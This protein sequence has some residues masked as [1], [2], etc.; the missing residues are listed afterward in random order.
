MSLP[1]N[2]ISCRLIVSLVYILD[3][4][5]FIFIFLLSHIDYTLLTRMDWYGWHLFFFSSAD[6]ILSS[7]FFPGGYTF[8]MHISNTSS[9]EH[10]IPVSR[11]KAKRKRSEG[12]ESFRPIGFRTCYIHGA[13]AS[14]CVKAQPLRRGLHDIW[15]WGLLLIY[16]IFIFV[17]MSLIIWTFLSPCSVF[18]RLGCICAC[19]TEKITRI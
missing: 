16:F 15:G 17:F 1:S 19:K 14:V 2:I 10:T 9:Y 7:L 18:G 11:K 5:K 4:Y 3:Y 6:R 12:K 13:C 8:C